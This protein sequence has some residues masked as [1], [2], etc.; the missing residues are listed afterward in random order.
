MREPSL[1]NSY[2]Q[3]QS[4]PFCAWLLCAAPKNPLGFWGVP[5][6]TR[7]PRPATA[8]PE[9]EPWLRFRF[10]T[11][12]TETRLGLFLPSPPRRGQRWCLFLLPQSFLGEK[13][14]ILTS[15]HLPVASSKRGGRFWHRPEE[16]VDVGHED[17]VALED[18]PAEAGLFCR[19]RSGTVI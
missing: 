6:R 15:P 16:G 4:R 9:E 18:L 8:G 13:G 5:L 14:T 3:N 11:C 17:S 2:L 1:N 19:A 10:V 12:N 7:M